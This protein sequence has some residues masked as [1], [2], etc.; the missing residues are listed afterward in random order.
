M[1]LQNQNFLSLNLAFGLNSQGGLGQAT[2]SL[3]CNVG[4]IMALQACCKD[5]LKK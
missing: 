2:L 1:E 3:D 5:Y 4:V